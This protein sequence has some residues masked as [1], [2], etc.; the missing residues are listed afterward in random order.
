MG[1]IEERAKRIVEILQ[2]ELADESRSNT[3][4]MISVMSRAR[5]FN[6]LLAEQGLHSEKL[7]DH[8]IAKRDQLSL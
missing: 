1:M 7:I 8:L 6:D 2:R 5:V 3:D 4:R